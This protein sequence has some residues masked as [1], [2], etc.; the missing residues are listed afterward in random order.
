MR[1]GVLGTGGV[2]QTLGAKLV[3]LGHEVMLGSRAGD[4][5]VVEGAG[6]GTFAD[7]AAFGELLINAT[8]GAASLAALHAADAANLAGK[9]LLDVANPLDF[10]QGFPP[11]LTV[12]NTDSLGEQIQRAFPEARVVKALN[13]INHLVMVDPGRVSGGGDVFVCGDNEEAKAQIHEL[14]GGLGWADEAIIDLGD[15]SA[16]RATEAYLLLWLRLM[17]ALGTADFNIKVAR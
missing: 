1:M 10:S 12:C 8:A 13:T 6:Q 11:A 7:A 4:K 14:L 3:G 9:V 17:G 2:G 15:I 5:R 16:A